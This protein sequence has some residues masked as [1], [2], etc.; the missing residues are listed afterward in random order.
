MADSPQ[1]S[2]YPAFSGV[3][4]SGLGT[5]LVAGGCSRSRARCRSSWLRRS[6]TRSA[7]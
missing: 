4:A 2:G 5:I 7:P 3:S 6:W 1:L